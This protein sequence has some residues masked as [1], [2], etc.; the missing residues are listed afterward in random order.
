MFHSAIVVLALLNPPSAASAPQ[1]AV[2]ASPSDSSPSDSSLAKPH[3]VELLELGFDAASRI[4]G[5]PHERDRARVQETVAR[6]AFQLG[7]KTRS[8][9]M[10]NQIANWRKGTIFADL[11]VDAAR[12]GRADAAET[13]SRFARNAVGGAQQWQSERVLARLAE[14]Q[15]VLGKSAEALETEKKFGESEKGKVTAALAQLPDADF[16]AILAEAERAFATGNFELTAN[17]L[18]ICA[19]LGERNDADDARWSRIEDLVGRAKGKVAREIHIRS[20]LRLAD[21]RIA[22]QAPAAA[23]AL[24]E[25]AKA[26]RDEVR[27]TPDSELPLTAEIARRLAAAGDRDAAIAELD[28]GLESFRS[29][30]RLV[31]DI[32]RAGALCPAAEAL[33]ALGEEERARAVYRAAIEAGALNPN[34]RPR[35]EDLAQTAASLARSGIEPDEATWARLRAIRDG[36]TDPW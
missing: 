32:F 1:A 8:A 22:R 11:A 19:R 16:D 4:P 35:A 26:L 36:L 6:T 33:V 7:L 12:A 34:A 10:A 14:A 23:R 21:A 18:E 29:N 31:A 2:E 9:A 28:K 3:Q 24:V 5:N 20:Y 17:A 30:E 25:R 13:F 15:V 27:W